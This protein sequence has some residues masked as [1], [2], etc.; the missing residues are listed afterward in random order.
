MGIDVMSIVDYVRKQKC[1]CT[2][3]LQDDV[4]TINVIVGNLA[5]KFEYDY[6]T[7]QPNKVQEDIASA[8]LDMKG[9][10]NK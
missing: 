2:A 3:G 8:I 5:K 1:N 4:L 6:K 7:V 9:K 10:L